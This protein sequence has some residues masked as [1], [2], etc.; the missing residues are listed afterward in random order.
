MCTFFSIDQSLYFHP[1]LHIYKLITLEG[2]DVPISK[3]KILTFGT[4]IYCND[5]NI[6]HFDK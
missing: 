4:I 2:G 3:T 1:Y 6:I 5:I